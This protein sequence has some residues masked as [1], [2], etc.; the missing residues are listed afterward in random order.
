MLNNI[1]IGK[2]YPISSKVHSMNPFAKICCLL[3]FIVSLFFCNDVR[4]VIILTM[5]AVLMMFNTHIP[6]SVYG[7]AIKSM[8]MLLVFVVGINFLLR[9]SIEMNVIILLRIV[10]IV[11]YTSMLT[12]TTPPNEITDGLEK[13]MSPLKLI[14]L[15]INRTALAIT[16]ALRFIPTIIDQGN[17][18]LKS[19]ASRGIDYYNS[20]LQG[21]FMALKAML[22]P[23]F[24]LT[25]KRADALA[26]S[27]EV[28]LYNVNKKR[29]N[30]RQNKWGF[31]DS[32]MLGIHVLMLIVIVV[33]GVVR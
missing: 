17:K 25:V 4:F 19:Q 2:Y 7:K 27:M 14:G 24:T 33:K 21:K 6:L 20:N 10:L 26:D 8:W 29:V 15:P 18:I 5:L 13:L 22:I 31:Y 9:I 11:L 32:F 28:R 3:I 1:M 30:F 23:M 16:L 12:L